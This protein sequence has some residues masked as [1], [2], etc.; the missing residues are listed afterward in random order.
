MVIDVF[1]KYGWIEG[2]NNKKTESVSKAF[3]DIF[4]KK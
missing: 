3:D 2:L 1:S 4:K